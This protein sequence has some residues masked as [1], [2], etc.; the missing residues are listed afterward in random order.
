M[1]DMCYK[2]RRAEAGVSKSKFSA[3]LGPRARGPPRG[4]APFIRKNILPTADESGTFLHLSLATPSDRSYTALH[5]TRETSR[6][7]GAMGDRA[8]AL[9]EALAIPTLIF[10]A[11]FLFS[12]TAIFCS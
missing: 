7:A 10:V 1:E 12:T 11:P 4:G 8:A 2:R 5:H 3:A 9:T 6:D